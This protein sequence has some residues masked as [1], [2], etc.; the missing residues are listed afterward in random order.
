MQPLQSE[1]VQPPVNT[2]PPKLNKTE[3]NSK[4]I[5]IEFRQEPQSVPLMRKSET[6]KET[7]SVRS[8]Y[9]PTSLDL[10]LKASAIPRR[11]PDKSKT[12][13]AGAL[14]ELSRESAFQVKFPSTEQ[15]DYNWTDPSL[16][17]ENKFKNQMSFLK[18]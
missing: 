8:C 9:A 1:S 13:G 12:L 10:D 14:F 16:D 3:L 2:K 6:K 4:P 18:R 15:Y 17:R 11:R 7:K 5:D